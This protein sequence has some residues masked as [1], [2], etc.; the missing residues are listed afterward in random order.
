[1]LIKSQRDGGGREW[2]HETR[3]EIFFADPVSGSALA[4][5]I[6]PYASSVILSISLSLSPSPISRPPQKKNRPPYVRRLLV[7]ARDVT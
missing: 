7:L 4:I 1:M 5:F 2:P 6:P 3:V